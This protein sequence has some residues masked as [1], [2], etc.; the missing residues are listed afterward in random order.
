MFLNLDY[1]I[2]KERWEEYCL[3]ELKRL[4]ECVKLPFK[5]RLID[6]FNKRISL[7]SDEEKRMVFFIKE[8]VNNAVSVYGDELIE[9]AKIGLKERLEKDYEWASC[10]RNYEQ[11]AKNN[12]VGAMIYYKEKLEENWKRIYGIP[13]LH[14]FDPKTKEMHG[15]N[16][17]VEGM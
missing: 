8:C 12:Y 11:A 16:D 4:C 1:E 6:I 2:P 9:T 7:Q 3:S 10:K 14:W 17:F 13:V 15:I 5:Q